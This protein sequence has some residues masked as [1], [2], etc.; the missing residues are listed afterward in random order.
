MSFN[1]AKCSMMVISKKRTVPTRDY[2]FCGQILQ[3][4]SS[5]PYL[6]VIL[7]EKLSWNDQVDNVVKKSN[8]TLGFI[9]RNLWF[10]PRDVK[11]LAYTTLVRPQ[12]EYAVCA[13]DPH[14]IT[15]INKLEGIQRKAARF[16]CGD[17]SRQ[18]SVT[19]MLSNL[20]WNTLES[21]RQKNR[22]AM[23]YKIQ[24]NMVSINADTY[25][26]YSTERRTR[27]I[28]TA[29]I[30][31]PFAR[32]DTYKNSFFPKTIRNWNNLENP[33]VNS[34]SLE[35]FKRALLT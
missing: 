8:K 22:L 18:S 21:R 11:S 16:C 25:L 29:Q 10:C 2:T 35:S 20:K 9:R 13:W 30:K 19:Q 5:H 1:P 7:D 14:K 17:Y 31:I 34:A 27:K 23:L 12:L 26:S 33:I 24:H 4:S 32:T 28:N 15:Q 3:R 6:G